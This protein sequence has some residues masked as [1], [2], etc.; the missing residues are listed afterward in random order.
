MYSTCPRIPRV[1]GCNML[2]LGVCLEFQCLPA[3]NVDQLQITDV[4]RANHQQY[5]GEAKL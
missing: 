4:S 1:D 2:Q 5:R 3:T